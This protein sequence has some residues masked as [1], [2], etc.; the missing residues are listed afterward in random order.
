MILRTLGEFGHLSYDD[1]I[2]F[3]PREAHRIEK[4]LADLIKEGFVKDYNGTLSL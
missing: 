4:N 1:L 3:I 2:V